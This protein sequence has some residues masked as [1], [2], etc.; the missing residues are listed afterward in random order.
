MKTMF[1][2]QKY[3][4]N[5]YQRTRVELN[6]RPLEQISRVVRTEP[7]HNSTGHG[8]YEIHILNTDF[9][10]VYYVTGGVCW[11]GGAGSYMNID[12]YT[13]NLVRNKHE[14]KELNPKSIRKIVSKGGI[15]PATT[16]S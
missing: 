5:A 6:L 7:P 2:F 15:E 12:G 14:C 4:K 1:H 3:P 8:L 16:R 10:Q 9:V 11:G 13:F